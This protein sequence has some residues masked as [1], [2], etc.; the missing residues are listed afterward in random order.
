MPQ[1]LQ[2]NTVNILISQI[3]DEGVLSHVTR[4]AQTRTYQGNISTSRQVG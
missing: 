3:I 1:R 2:E 4:H